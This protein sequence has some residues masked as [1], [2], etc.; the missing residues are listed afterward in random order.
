MAPDQ[1]Q[2]PTS[3]ERQGEG[4]GAVPQTA[5]CPPPPCRASSSTRV[6]SSSQV[7]KPR[8]GVPTSARV[9]Q[10][11]AGETHMPTRVHTRSPR[12]AVPQR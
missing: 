12:A 3:R 4:V 9:G 7:E 8:T 11:R 5:S 6:E 2:S 1:E 10:G